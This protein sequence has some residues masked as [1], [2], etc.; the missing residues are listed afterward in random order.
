MSRIFNRSLAAKVSLAAVLATGV[1]LSVAP[2]ASAKDGNKV[3]NCL[4]QYFSTSWQ[5]VC[6]GSGATAAGRYYSEAECN[7]EGNEAL[8]KTRKVGSKEVAPGVDCT[9]SVIDVM[10]RYQG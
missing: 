10:T 9:F 7:W 8:F 4:G 1:G 6:H 3:N 2:V 5:Q